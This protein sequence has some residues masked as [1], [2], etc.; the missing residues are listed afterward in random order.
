MEVNIIVEQLELE[1]SLVLVSREQP[2]K[3]DADRC[4]RVD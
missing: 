1:H 3:K 2:F 4:R